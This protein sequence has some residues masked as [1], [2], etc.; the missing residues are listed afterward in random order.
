MPTPSKED[1]PQKIV[2]MDSDK[3]ARDD[4]PSD[5]TDFEKNTTQEE[6]QQMK[7]DPNNTN[8]D[9]ARERQERGKHRPD[10]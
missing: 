7:D 4:D 1:L 3:P 8:A 10:N 5:M 2:H 9:V 6:L